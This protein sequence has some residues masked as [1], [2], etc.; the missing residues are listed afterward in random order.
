MKYIFIKV[1][2]FG[3]AA[4]VAANLV[5]SVNSTHEVVVL[6]DEQWAGNRHSQAVLLATENAT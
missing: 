5:S 6:H 3:S 2:A 4:V 1:S